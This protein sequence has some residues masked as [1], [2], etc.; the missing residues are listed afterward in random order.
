MRVDLSQMAVL[1]LRVEK[2]MIALYISQYESIL[3]KK[4]LG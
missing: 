1:L 2:R 4:G 3:E